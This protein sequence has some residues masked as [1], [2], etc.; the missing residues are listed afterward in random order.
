MRFTAL[1]VPVRMNVVNSTYSQAE[2]R[3]RGAM[4][5]TYLKNGSVVDAPGSVGR[6]GCCQRYQ[7]SDDADDDLAGELVPLDEPLVLLALALLLAA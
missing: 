6:A 5:R 3:R 7:P 1:L 4:Q 2:A